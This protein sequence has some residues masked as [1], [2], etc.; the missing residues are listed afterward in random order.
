VKLPYAPIHARLAVAAGDN[1]HHGQRDPY[2]EIR[3]YLAVP[4]EKLALVG[5]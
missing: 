2:P 4:R 3:N 5:R 1:L